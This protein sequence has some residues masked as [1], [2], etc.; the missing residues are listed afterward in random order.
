LIGY[1]FFKQ[2]EVVW[3]DNQAGL[4]L[5]SPP[6]KLNDFNER[7]ARLLMKKSGSQF[8]RWE[9]HFDELDSGPWWHVVKTDFDDL[10]ALKKKTRRDVRSGLNKYSCSPIRRERVLEEGYQVYL[11]AF[12]RYDTHEPIFTQKSFQQAI[13]GLPENTE[14][15]GAEDEAGELVAF[16][17]NYI[18]SETCFLN[19]MWFRPSALRQCVAYALFYEMHRHYLEERKFDYVSD[20]ARSISHNSS[21]HDFLMSKFGYRKAYANLH[22][23]YKHWLYMAVRLVFPFRAFIARVNLNPLIK[24]SILLRQEE[25][26]RQCMQAN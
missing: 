6:K 7:Q 16:S 1:K 14:F 24:V 25:I 22:V 18:E 20:G 19:T 8:L 5:L 12:S 9:S 21:I 11:D 23:V 17:E 15:W 26:R 2:N 4:L 3:R 10:Q 13:N